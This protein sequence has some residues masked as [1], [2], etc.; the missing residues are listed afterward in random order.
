MKIRK[1]AVSIL[2]AL[3]LAA[4]LFYF[5]YMRPRRVTPILMYHSISDD[6]ANTLSVTPENFSKQMEFLGKTGYSVVSLDGLVESIT[7]GKTYLP[8]TV[9]ITFDDGY[10]DN[11]TNAFPVLEKHDMT[12]AVFLVTNYVDNKKEYLS[13]DQVRLMQKNGIE[14]GGHT[15][16]NAYLPL[17]KDQGVLWH[18]IAGCKSDIESRTGEE[19]KYFCYPI[20][21]FTEEVKAIVK[22]AGYRG[23]C[24]TNRGYDKSNKDVYEL[25]R[26]KVTDS[27]MNKPF[28][29][30]AK[31]SGYYNLFRSYRSGS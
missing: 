21:G 7:D 24:T 30:R 31:L 5:F 29:F 26:I 13:W 10:K 22:K 20:G 3:F 12:A 28:H 8:K 15:R 6:K 23:A 16:N 11:F 9:V 1:T 17:E 19:A 2:L 25:N 18:E 14:F 4:V 27:D